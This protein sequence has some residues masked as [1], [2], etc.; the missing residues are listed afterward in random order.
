M[1][2]VF[3]SGIR[4]K[5]SERLGIDEEIIDYI[6]DSFILEQTIHG[7]SIDETAEEYGI[8]PNDVAET[9]ERW[10]GFQG[11]TWTLDYD[12]YE[13]F[14]G[15]ETCADYVKT[16]MQYGAQESA[17]ELFY[18]NIQQFKELEKR[19]NEVYGIKTS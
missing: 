6:A 16:V 15:S 7:I 9:N 10:F 1:S 2:E 5:L 13:I 14:R 17:A 12:P 8:Y 11:W 19:S 18:K 4:K 3:W